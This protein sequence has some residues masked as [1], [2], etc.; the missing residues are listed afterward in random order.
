MTART[1]DPIWESLRRQG[2]GILRYPADFVVVFVHRYAPHGK[3]RK[4]VNILELGCGAGNNLWFAAREGFIVTGIDGSTAAIEY[5][6][7]RF[8]RERLDG[9]FDV[10]DYTSLPYDDAT[11]DLVI[12]CG[13]L[14]CCGF[15][16]GRRAVAESHRVLRSG[17]HFLFNP[18]STAHSCYTSSDPGED[19]VR[20]NIRGSMSGVGQLC[21][22]TRGDIDRALAEGWGVVS[23]V[24]WEGVE[25]VEAAPSAHAEW[26]VVAKKI[27]VA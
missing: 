17:G 21:Y 1:F 16:A 26:R 23:I 12:D 15:S 2:R 24:H 4:H 18:Y 19:G 27:E 20:I 11:F 25:Q 8:V 14:V 7:E 10:G 3:P 6:R 9:R 22:Y 5:A 13:A